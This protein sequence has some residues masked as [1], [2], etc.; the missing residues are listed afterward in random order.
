M[1]RKPRR[2]YALY[3]SYARFE[4]TPQR[5]RRTALQT[6]QRALIEQPK[7]SLDI[8]IF[9]LAYNSETLDI[10][11]KEFSEYSWS[12]P[13]L[14]PNAQK[15]NPLFEN[16]IYDQ[17]ETL[18]KPRIKT[19]YVGFLSYKAHTKINVDKLDAFFQKESFLKYDA[20]FFIS[21]PKMTRNTHPYF[22]QIWLEVL[23]NELGPAKDHYAC[24]CNFWCI[25]TPLLGLYTKFFKS[26]LP[27]LLNHPKILENAHY[28]G[29]LRPAQLREIGGKPYYTHV[30]FVLERIPYAW[31]ASLKLSIN[32]NMV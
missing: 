6:P 7:K 2:V 27:K 23:Q 24:Y 25:K 16:I 15:N 26:I 13:L 29:K 18:I 31:A 28:D 14:L 17:Y 10:A 30:P 1:F 9:V 8:Q 21:G 12:V 20:S 19:K 3:P 32:R 11:T 5:A 4:T 22:Q